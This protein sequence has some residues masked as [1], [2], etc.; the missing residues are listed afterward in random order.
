MRYDGD[1]IVYCVVNCIGL[2]LMQDANNV[3][4][5]TLSWV[6]FVN[7]IYLW[8]FCLMELIDVIFGA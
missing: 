1:R 2:A 8:K 3:L 5:M 7:F 6:F 4:S